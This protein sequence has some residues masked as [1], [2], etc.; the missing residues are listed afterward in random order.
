MTRAMLKQNNGGNKDEGK[1]H[2]KRGG[3]K[4]NGR[5][6]TE[7]HNIICIIEKGWGSDVA[8]NLGQTL[9]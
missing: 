6:K 1:T 9:T 5:K 7:V 4:E 2:P 3:S 8:A